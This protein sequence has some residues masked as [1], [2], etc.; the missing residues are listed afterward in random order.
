MLKEKIKNREKTIGMHINFNDISVG[1]IVGSAGYDFIWIDMEHSYLPY[2]GLL[3]LIMAVKST[4]TSVIVRAPQNDLTTTKK[5]LE[6]GVD[7]I[8]FPMIKTPEDANQLISYTLYPPYGI[9]GFGPMNAINYGFDSVTDYISTNHKTMC[10]FIQIEHIDAVRNLDEIIKNEYIDGYIIG[11]N[12]L[13]GS[14]GKLG[15]VFDPEI[16][17]IIKN[18]VEKLK[19][20]NKYVGISTGDF[21]E[22]TLKHWHDMG[23]DM[24]SAGADFDF[25]R[26]GVKNNRE[27]LKK[28]HLEAM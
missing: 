9:R 18:V 27:T 2:E 12:D 23:F 19:K 4:G 5:I 3:N 14:V 25:L 22:T 15:E 10:R 1:K 6:M 17:D 11:A 20:A 16:T 21:S 24:I 28:I 7:G 8:I 26:E 13:S